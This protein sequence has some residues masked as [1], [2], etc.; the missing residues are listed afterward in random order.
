MATL[1]L[2]TSQAGAEEVG[3]VLR[4][5][6]QAAA[7]SVE[8]SRSLREG[9]RL[10]LGDRLTTGPGARLMAVLSDGSELTLG[11]NTDFTIDELV[12]EK[13]RGSA[14]FHL[15]KGAFRMV[16][17][18][19]A[20]VPEHRMEI[21]APLGTIGIRGTDVWGGSLKSP[22]DVFLIEGEISVSTPGGAVILSKPG[23]GTSV[24]AA[25]Q[26]PLPPSDW[27]EDLRRRAF[28]TVSFA[29]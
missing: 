14:L 10:S 22:M 3:R 27:S 12:L 2:F 24:T 26:A 20:K 17:G 16:G 19:I 25:G 1:F 23:Q 9:D 7:S 6:G 4:L 8:T 21:A 29:P 13:D 11:A 15:A 18:A 5:Q 28:A